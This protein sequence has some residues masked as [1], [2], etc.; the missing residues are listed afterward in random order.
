MSTHRGTTTPMRRDLSRSVAVFAASMLIIVGV[1][2]ILLGITAVA[3][4]KIYANGVDY[5]YQFDVTAWGWVHLVVGAC[6]IAVGC[7]SLME[8]WWAR[9]GGI[10]VAAIGI[11]SNFLFLPYFPFWAVVLIGFY[12]F[13][14][15]AL[16]YQLNTDD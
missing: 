6:A 4:D 16:A 8:Q 12:V 10:M 9:V 14:I 5:S 1:C 11:M 2:Q 13:V 3:N 7:G 15:W